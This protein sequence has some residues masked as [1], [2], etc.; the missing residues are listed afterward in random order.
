MISAARKT[1]TAD[2]LTDKVGAK[3]KRK[4]ASYVFFG[5]SLCIWCGFAFEEGG[6]PYILLLDA[7]GGRERPPQE[8][9]VAKFHLVRGQE[10]PVAVRDVVHAVRRQRHPAAAAAAAAARRHGAVA[11]GVSGRGRLLRVGERGAA[12]DALGTVC[13]VGS[14]VLILHFL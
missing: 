6:A 8:R 10:R 13:C 2:T 7:G 5:K 14:M 3:G 12:V 1:F 4:G 11:V 9:R